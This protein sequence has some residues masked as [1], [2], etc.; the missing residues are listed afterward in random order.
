M[1]EPSCEDLSFPEP[2][3]GLLKAPVDRVIAHLDTPDAVVAAI[4]DLAE[5]GFDRDEIYVL[6]GQQGAERLDVSGRHHGLGGRIYR[7]LEWLGDEHEVLLKSEQHLAAGGLVMGVPADEDVKE[8]ASRI[9]R[10]RGGHEIY[11][12]GK[13]D[14]QR[15]GA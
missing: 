5:A 6:C 4:D 1:S 2:P 8:A 12:F 9:L 3:E 14:W 13:T 10:E 15:L 7:F 11:H